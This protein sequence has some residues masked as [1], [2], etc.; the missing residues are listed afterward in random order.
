[1]IGLDS[2]MPQNCKECIFSDV[3]V[4]MAGATNVYCECPGSPTCGE[5]VKDGETEKLPDCP[6]I[7]LAAWESEIRAGRPRGNDGKE[8]G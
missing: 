1:M 2:Q 8:N 5:W 7:D 4:T 6:L 3:Y